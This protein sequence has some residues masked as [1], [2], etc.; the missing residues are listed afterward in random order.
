MRL[1]SASSK[2][3]DPRQS[4]L[5][6][7]VRGVSEIGIGVPGSGQVGVDSARCLLRKSFT[8]KDVIRT[9]CWQ[10]A[11]PK[12]YRRQETPAVATVT[13]EASRNFG[14]MQQRILI[15]DD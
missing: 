1:V 4:P 11:C 6:G 8:Q 10:S 13:R 9:E 15:A 12:A 3:S 5:F 2:G 14:A 7:P